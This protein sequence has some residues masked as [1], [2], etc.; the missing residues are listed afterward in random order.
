VNILTFDIED[1]Y[2]C[3][4]ISSDFNWDKYEVRIY[5]GVDKILQELEKRNLKATFFCLGWIAEKHPDAILRIHKQGHHIGCHS[6][7]HELSFRF[8]SD[9]FRKDVEKSK[10]LIEDLI[11]EPVNAFRAP[12]FSITGQNLWA[13][14]ILSELGF[15]YDCS[16]FPAAHDYGGF[17]SY[18]KAEPAILLLPDGLQMKEFPINIQD[19]FGKK[20][21]FTGG[22]FFRIFPYRLIHYWALRSPYMMTYFHTRDFDPGQPRVESLPLTRKFKSYVG[23]SSSFAK[24]QK[25]L[26]DFEFVS[27]KEADELT[28][29]KLARKIELNSFFK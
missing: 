13:L 8:D 12:G 11:G 27:L 28:D 23:L 17:S 22:G 19:V 10:K 5:E 25:L 24:F 4:F 21:A 20:F 15:E 3:D 29:W 16:I 26:N 9:G 18:G 14:K 7:Q 1:W 2:N 6:Y